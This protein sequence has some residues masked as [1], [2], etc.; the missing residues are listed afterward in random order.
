MTAPCKGIETVE[1]GFH[2]VLHNFT[3]F[4]SPLQSFPFGNLIKSSTIQYC[5]I[6]YKTE[7]IHY[8]SIKHPHMKHPYISYQEHTVF[9]HKTITLVM[10]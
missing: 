9:I 4:G 5:Q 2:L 6:Q 7:L 8:T 1:T 10:Q 3:H